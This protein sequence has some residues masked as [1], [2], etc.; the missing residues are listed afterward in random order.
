MKTPDEIN[1]NCECECENCPPHL[2]DCCPFY[3]EFN[4]EDES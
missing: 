4:D 3:L 2:K 1:D